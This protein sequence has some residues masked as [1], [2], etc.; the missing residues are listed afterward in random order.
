MKKS[1]QAPDRIE[2]VPI[3]TNFI[4]EQYWLE[5]ARELDLTLV[6]KLWEPFYP[7][8]NERLQLLDELQALRTWA[9]ANTMDDQLQAD[10]MVERIDLLRR[11]L[12]S[13][14]CDEFEFCF[15]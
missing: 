11:A 5:G 9:L 6:P 13:D 10:H 8:E 12:E 14:T 2:E 4:F 3:A 15:G 7:D 1:R